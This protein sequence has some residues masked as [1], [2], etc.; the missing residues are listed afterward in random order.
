MLTFTH[1]N[2]GEDTNMR[3]L[4]MS[5]AV[6]GL[7]VSSAA[8]AEETASASEAPPKKQKLVCQTVAETGSRLRTKKTCHTREEWEE[9]RQE[10]RTVTERVQSNRPTFGN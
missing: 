2:Y 3:V 10:I 9:L 6:L 1:V 7:S 4:L 8:R 5:I